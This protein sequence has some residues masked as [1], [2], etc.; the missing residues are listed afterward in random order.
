MKVKNITKFL[1]EQYPIENASDFDIPKLGLQ[2]GSF[3]HEV[4]NIMLALDLTIEVVEEA[5]SKN[6]NLIIVHHPF[7]FN[8]LQKIHF[9]SSVGK[10]LSLMFKHQISLYAMHTNLDVG[11]HG[12]NDT[13]ATKLQFIDYKPSIEN[14]MK[15]NFIRYGNIQPQTLGEYALIVK[16]SLELTGVRVVG[17]L[18][19]V[20]KK[21]AVIGGSGGQ[22]EQINRAIALGC[23]LLVTG[24]VSHH[25]AHYAITND[26]SIIEVS[27]GVERFVF[28][29]LAKLLQDNFR[30]IK[31]LES[32]ANVDP[33]VVV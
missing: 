29:N 33:F 26:F 28:E 6:A 24:E 16:S 7:I 30:T 10:I 27:H 22:I 5:I 2:I 20:I 12:V 31:V 18:E 32:N 25:V 11:L 21:V 23:D 4:T 15:D 13:L 8:P 17:D 3:D 1:E 14:V 19:K 9:D